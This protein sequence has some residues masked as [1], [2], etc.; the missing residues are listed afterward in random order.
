V[1]YQFRPVL[2]FIRADRPRLLIAD[3]VGVGKTIEAGLIL[4]ELQARRDIRSVLIL[5]PRPLVVERKWQLEMQWF[6]ED[7]HHL[8]GP[9]LRYYLRETDR[10][11]IWPERYAKCI[12]LFSLFDERLLH[13][14]KG[15]QATGLLTL[16]P[17]PHFDLVIVDEIHHARNTN[18]YVHQGIP[19]IKGWAVQQKGPA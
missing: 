7:F 15:R 4:R 14:G 17:P 10:N 9:M 18:T 19:F 1:P 6:D 8:D 11:G 13:G 5:C 12:L 16:D 3:E 2:R